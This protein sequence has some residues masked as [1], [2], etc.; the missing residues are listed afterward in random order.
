ME[1]IFWV[2][3]LHEVPGTNNMLYKMDGKK[4]ILIIFDIYNFM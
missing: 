4:S 2:V 3:L 1:K